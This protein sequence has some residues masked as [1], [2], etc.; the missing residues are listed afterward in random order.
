MITAANRAPLESAVST[1]RKILFRM[2]EKSKTDARRREIIDRE[3]K[4]M[5]CAVFNYG[6]DADKQEF[7]ALA[8]EVTA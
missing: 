1:Y 4:T 2:I 6:S 5:C 3:L 7:I 8:K